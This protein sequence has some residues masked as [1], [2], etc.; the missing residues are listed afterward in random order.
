MKQHMHSHWW[1]KDNNID[2]GIFRHV[3]AIDE[4]QGYRA[5]ED[6]MHAR[7]YGNAYQRDL[8]LR[9]YSRQVSR[10][11]MHRVTMNICANMVDTVAAKLCKNR[12]KATFL[13]SGGDFSQQRKA[14]RLDKFVFGQFYHTNIYAV[15]PKVVMDALIFGTGFLKVF[16]CSQRGITCERVLPSE[17]LCDDHESMYARPQTM[18]QRKYISLET[19]KGIYPHLAERLDRVEHAEAH[20]DRHNLPPQLEVIEAWHLPAVKGGEGRHTICVDGLVLVDELYHKMHFPFVTLRYQERLLGYYGRGLIEALTGIQIELNRL[21]RAIQEQQHLAKPKILVEMGSQV[22]KMQ[23]SNEVWGVINYT[24]T[25]PTFFVPKTVSPDVVN[26]IDR[27]YNRAFE[28]AGVSMLDATSRKPAGLES[29]VALREY[30]DITT[31][32]F[33]LLA[34]RYEQA[35]LDA[36]KLMI[37]LARDLHES[38]EDTEVISHG[39]K[40]IEKIKWSEI[41]LQDDMYVMKVFPT[42]LLPATPAAKLQRTIEMLQGGLLDKQQALVLLDYPDLESVN[43]MATAAYKDI[44]LIIE[45]M[46]EN[47][48]YHVPEPMMNI[49]MALKMVNSAYLHAKVN[50]APEE[51]LDLLRRFLEESATLL[52]SQLASPFAPEPIQQKLAQGPSGATPAGMPPEMAAEGGMPPNQAAVPPMM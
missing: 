25:P 16:Q 20:E 6:L 27:L 47:G 3:R 37:D 43:N 46:L 34:Q 10:A 5:Q 11:N 23:L 33:M 21:L 26:H 38:G 29:G 44:Q 12:P 35:F 9:G 51:R 45:E 18:Y 8:S 30:N 2:E 14:R 7:L 28:I 48:K 50:G 52:Q 13:T 17:I 22:S 32:R 36:G 40:D 41:Q 49:P 4:H 24:G 1:L 39:D 19:L 42:N 15:M 31:E